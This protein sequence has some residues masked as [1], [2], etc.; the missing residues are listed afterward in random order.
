M[1]L[2]EWIY[3]YIL[4]YGYSGYIAIFCA[5]GIVDILLYFQVIMCSGVVDILLFSQVIPYY[6][7][8]VYICI[9]SGDDLL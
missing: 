3:Y 6:S 4:C 8:S 1:L 7:L 2:I 5:I 9:F